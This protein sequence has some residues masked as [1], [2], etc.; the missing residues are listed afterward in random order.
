[1]IEDLII[2]TPIYVSFFWGIV[3]LF[4]KDKSNPARN[5]LSIFMLVSFLLFFSH[6]IFFQESFTLYPYFDPVYIFTSLS[7]YP[8]AFWYIKLLTIETRLRISNLRMLA[9]AAFFASVSVIVYLLMDE[10]QIRNYVRGVLFRE[11]EDVEFSFFVH[12]QKWNFII[13][14]IFY[15][16]Q[17][18]Y[19][20]IQGR[21]L[22]IRYN[23]K[24]ADFYS[25]LES[26]NI[27]WVNLFLYSFV[28]ASLMS[29]V[30]NIIGRS[31]FLDSFYL[32]LIPSFIFSFLLFLIGLQGNMQIH[33]VADLIRDEKRQSSPKKDYS[34]QNLRKH[35]EELFLQEKIY[36]NPELKITDVAQFLGTNRSYIS[37]LIN[38]VFFC[39]FSEFVNRYRIREAKAIL[40]D[41]THNNYSLNYIA[42]L[43]GFGS[44]GTFIR[45]F[46]VFENKTPGK[47]REDVKEKQLLNHF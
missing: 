44:V 46:R 32:L 11:K 39:S 47:Y 41:E 20:L 43:V 9:P 7:V 34:K 30:F 6:I 31:V 23:R 12:L 19:F 5:F 28:I 38:N 27:D 29:M 35:L 24:I 42:E 14:R 16:F 33:T 4:P 21:R 18:L 40:S 37:G 22:V 17:I 10:N 13:S 8:I 26:K 15:L 25:N 1:M 45:V 36:R 2:Y 3:L